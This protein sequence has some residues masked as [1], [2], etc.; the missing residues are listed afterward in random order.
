MRSIVLILAIFFVQGCVTNQR[1]HKLA[2]TFDSKEASFIFAS[3]KNE[4]KGSALVR[5][6]GGGIVTCAGSKISLVPRTSYAD[7]R[8]AVLYGTTSDSG[9]ILGLINTTF[10]GDSTEY[11]NHMKESVCDAQ[12][13]FSFK[14]VAD[15]TYYII[16]SIWWR[17]PNSNPF[18]N[19]QSGANMMR[20]VEA[21]GGQ[22]VEV[23]LSP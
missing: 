23:V 16:A 12:G 9:S 3:G 10:D 17:L 19:Q 11:L 4:I 6:A 20:R 14:N 15:G 22:V 1:T 5:Q 8:M 18:V 13:F 2:S 21:K 7:E